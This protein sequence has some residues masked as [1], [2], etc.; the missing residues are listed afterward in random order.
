MKY[1]HE[2]DASANFLKLILKR[3]VEH[4]AAFTPFSYAVW[5]EY[6]AGLNPRLSEA[7]NK[8]FDSGAI[9]D[10]NAIEA[11]Y[12]QYISDFDIN[13]QNELH[14]DIKQ[15]LIKLVNVVEDT[16]KQALGFGDSLEKYCVALKGKLTTKE[17]DSLVREM[18]KD[19]D[20]MRSAM[21]QMS[22]QL[23]A[24]K[25][26]IELLHQEL[27]SVR[28]ESMTDPLAGVLNRRGFES[29][30][31]TFF[32]DPDVND[33][34][35]SLLMIDI[36]YFKKVNDSY[37]HPFGDKVISVIASTIK[38]LVKGQDVIARLGGEEFAVLL[39]E[40]NAT[41]AFVIAEKIRQ[42]IEHG[43]IRRLDNNGEVGGITV[44]I[45]IATYI[46]GCSLARLIDQADRALYLSKQKGRNQTTLY[47][48][49]ESSPAGKPRG[50]KH[51]NRSDSTSR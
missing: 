40:T 8:I 21:Q 15:L 17:L 37:G 11:L 23:S 19:T 9:L 33:S 18:M 7:L 12:A 2:R 29:R 31:N 39:P 46:K 1:P 49:E 47:A 4:P 6:L 30:I 25:L 22:A 14:E 10:D 20:V 32:S 45:G 28:G 16:D 43:K 27:E 42:N 48:N 36:D 24:S 35:L 50:G 41:G 38:S 3:M 26:E 44:S 13:T 34:S 51:K 5:Y